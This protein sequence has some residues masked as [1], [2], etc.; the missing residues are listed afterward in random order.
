MKI[1][2]RFMDYVRKISFMT[3]HFK[4][5]KIRFGCN[6]YHA[7]F[8]LVDPETNAIGA[9]EADFTL[10]NLKENETRAIISCVM[11]TARQNSKRKKK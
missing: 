7:V 6:D 8:A 11:G 4:G 9:W 1:N 2:E 10:P 3:I 5:P